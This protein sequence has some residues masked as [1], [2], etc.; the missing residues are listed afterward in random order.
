MP[1]ARATALNRRKK[2]V[3]S[4]LPP[5]CDVK[6]KSEPSAGPRTQPSPKRSTFVQQRLT[7]VLEERLC[8]LHGALEAPNHDSPGFQVYIGELEPANLA[9]SHSVAV[10]VKNHGPCAGSVLAV[11][12]RQR[13]MRYYNRRRKGLA[14]NQQEREKLFPK[15]T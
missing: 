1:A 11:R 8:G 14:R 7:T 12:P 5:F 3:R 2:A 15:S 4:S 10:A 9:C 13:N 6:R